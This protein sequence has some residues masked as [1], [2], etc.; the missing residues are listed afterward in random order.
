MCYF[1]WDT[2]YNNY[3]IAIESKFLPSRARVYSLLILYYLNKT[4]YIYFYG[5]DISSLK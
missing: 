2:L 3:I 1:I 5:E 4:N